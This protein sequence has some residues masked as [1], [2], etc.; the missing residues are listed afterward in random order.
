MKLGG[1]TLATPF[2][3]SPM[4]SVSD[5]PWRRLCWSLGAGFTWT[6]MIRARGITRNNRSTL[7][8]IDSWDAEVPTGLQLMVVNEGELEEALA[9]I[10]RLA[11]STHPH[12]Q[13]LRA[14]DLN[15][16]CPSPEVIRVGAGPALLKRK[17]K[18]RAIFEVLRRFQ[19]STSLPIRAVTAKIRL[20]LNRM[21][22]DQQVYLPIVEL[23]N[24]L[25]DA[26]TVHA[27][28]AREASNTAAHWAAI[29][30]V[31]RR[32]TIPI[33][34]NGD[35]TSLDSAQRLMRETGCDGVMVARGAIRSP[36][37]F[38]ELTGRGSGLP[39]LEELDRAEAEW[40]EG[41]TRLGSKPKFFEWHAEGFRRMR[42][43]VTGQAL[44]GPSM[45][46]TEHMA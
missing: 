9:R 38:R 43:R 35:V 21:E 20:G 18:L 19:R 22:M 28:H 45:P 34:G 36:W 2:L 10:E 42:A 27:R 6:E 8:L 31:K 14:V 11:T 5:A 15:F 12:F 40:R 46:K 37:I 29:A 33:I 24:E 4:E 7:E 17:H 44:A 32:A 26:L 13:N 25:L 30:E 41:A 3:L 1:L 39:T 23:A 16:G